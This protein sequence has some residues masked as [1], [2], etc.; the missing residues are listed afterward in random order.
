MYCTTA[1]VLLLPLLRS[2]SMYCTAFV[3]SDCVYS[4][5][6]SSTWGEVPLNYRTVNITCIWTCFEMQFASLIGSSSWRLVVGRRR[7]DETAG[8]GCKVDCKP[9]FLSLCFCMGEFKTSRDR[10]W[11]SE[12]KEKS[13]AP[14]L[15]SSCAEKQQHLVCQRA[16]YSSQ[17]VHHHATQERRR[18]DSSTATH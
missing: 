17:I 16:V 18:C 15:S 13:L 5:S 7:R 8:G 3:F 4:L 2:I 12:K 6:L 14:T 9:F 1:V 11:V 10:R